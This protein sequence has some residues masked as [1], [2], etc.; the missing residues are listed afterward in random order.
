MSKEAA[1]LKQSLDATNRWR[2]A[3]NPLRG[4]T[5]PRAVSL[6]EQGQRGIYADLQWLYG[7]DTGI[8]ATDPDL[9]VIIERT[10]AFLSDCAWRVATID[11][12]TEGFDK[13]L[14][15][16]QAALLKATYN[17]VDNIED[18]VQHLCM[19]RFRGFAHIVPWWEGGANERIT[20]MEILHQWNM[21][22]NGPRGA[23][24][25]NPMAQAIGWD[26]LPEGNRLDPRDYVVVE[27]PRMINRIALIKYVRACVAE[28]DWDS[29]VEIYGIPGVFIIMP[30][31]VPNGQEAEYAAKAEA[32]AD[33]GSG[34]LPAGS[35]VK[36]MTEARGMQPFQARL[37][38]LQKQLV[39]AGTGGL[40]TMLSEAGSGTLAGS[41]HQQ[42]FAAIG[43]RQARIISQAMQRQLDAPLLAARFP[44]RPVHAYFELREKQETNVGDAVKN[45]VALA[46]AGYVVPDDQVAEA[47]GYDVQYTPPAT[48]APAP[49]GA[50]SAI[51]RGRGSHP[52]APVDPLRPILLRAAAR[53]LDGSQ[54]LQDALAAAQRDLDLLPGLVTQ[55]AP[56]DLQARL[57]SAMFDAAAQGAEEKGPS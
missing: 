51:A 6:M 46:G 12:E 52:A 44:G 39:L 56:T 23:W 16:D 47:V 2:D 32:A 38:W 27:N 49:A 19:A 11:P 8:E 9:M 20:H 34:A 18:A 22:R 29:Y 30:Q 43:R 36:A 1:K 13:A 33:A 5:M 25:W 31:Q 3:H 53:I 21:V 42:A 7:A 54:T 48:P 41:V 37:E 57:E 10:T 26:Q 4:L 35:E 15:D 24:A 14:A 28:K 55:V 45:I 50:A 17:A 40:L